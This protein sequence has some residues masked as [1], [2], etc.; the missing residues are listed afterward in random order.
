MKKC[1]YCAEEIQDE[2]IKCKHCGSML[3]NEQPIIQNNQ[4]KSK[5]K[6][7]YLIAAGIL[8]AIIVLTF[9]IVQASRDDSSPSVVVGTFIAKVRDGD[10]DGARSILTSELSGTYPD[11]KLYSLDLEVDRDAWL[12]DPDSV[13]IL[14]DGAFE[15]ILRVRDNKLDSFYIMLEKTFW[16]WKIS[17]IK[18]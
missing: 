10:I 17:D 16:G 13:R 4:H 6:K 1:P 18:N 9:M 5:N 3:A 2:A 11:S 15:R 7:M 14:K 8:V 12:S